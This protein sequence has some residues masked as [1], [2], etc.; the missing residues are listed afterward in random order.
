MDEEVLAELVKEAA[1]LLKRRRMV[2]TTFVHGCDD[3]FEVREAA[4][5]KL[6]IPVGEGML[7]ELAEEA[8]ALRKLVA[9]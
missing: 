3:D 6:A 4:T 2:G 8:A 9:A 7:V 1:A 5:V